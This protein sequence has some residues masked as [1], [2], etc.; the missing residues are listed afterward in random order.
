VVSGTTITVVSPAQAAGQRNI[1]VTT[2]SGTS[3]TVAGDE[4]T[5]T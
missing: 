3:P 4:F 1:Q 5:Y 2:P